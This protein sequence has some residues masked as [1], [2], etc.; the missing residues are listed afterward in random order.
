[1]RMASRYAP[2]ASVTVSKLL[3][4]ASFTPLIVTPGSTPPVVTVTVPVTA[5]SCASPARGTPRIARIAAARTNRLVVVDFMCTSLVDDF[6]VAVPERGR[7]YTLPARSL[8]PDAVLTYLCRDFYCRAM[9]ISA[10]SRPQLFPCE[11]VIARDVLHEEPAAAALHELDAESIQTGESGPGGGDQRDVPSAVHVGEQSAVRERDLDDSRQSSPERRLLLIRA[12]VLRENLWGDVYL[13]LL[14]IGSLADPVLDAV[15]AF[16]ADELDHFGIGRQFGANGD[17]PRLCVSRRVGE[18]HLELEIAEVAAAVAFG[19]AQAFSVRMAIV[20]EPRAIVESEALHHQRVSIPTPNRISHPTWIGGRFQRAAVEEDLAI[21]EIGI[22]NDDEPGG[23]DDFHHLRA[24]DVG[25][26][27]VARPQRHALHVHVILAEI[28]SALIDQRPR[29]RLSLLGLQV[30][31]NVA[32]ILRGNPEPQAREIGFGVRRARRGRRQIRSAVG[33]ARNSRRGMIQPL[34][35]ERRAQRER[36][37][38]DQRGFHRWILLLVRP[39]RCGRGTAGP[40]NYPTNRFLRRASRIP[41]QFRTRCRCTEASGPSTEP[42]ATRRAIRRRRFSRN[43]ACR[44]PRRGS[45]CGRRGSSR[46]TSR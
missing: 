16:V 22:E 33:R 17:R 3:P 36:D 4:D 13:V 8:R 11:A 35:R 14:L 19:R 5:A 31:G 21:R 30:R 24:G 6:R 34:S 2:R 37:G 38:G 27:G 46:R 7:C 40:G 26:G 29:P 41:V 42:R 45:S 25:G 9:T 1:M 20:I 43:A 15:I 39:Q 44:R 10:Q 28:F 23:L 18:R 12:D 32:R